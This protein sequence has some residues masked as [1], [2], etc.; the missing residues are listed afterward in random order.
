MGGRYSPGELF[1]TEFGERKAKEVE[2]ILNGQKATP[3]LKKVKPV[4]RSVDDKLVVFLKE[5]PQFG[6]FLKNSSN[7]SMSE[8]EFRNILRCTLETPK[9]V[10]KQNLEYC[11]NLAN[12]YNEKQLLE[13][14]V[15]CER[16]FIKEEG[17]SG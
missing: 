3:S 7:F 4:K 2:A 11:K 10:L 16:K 14:L 5:S 8:P 9:R 15:F 6:A 1:L 12:S 17:K 13:F